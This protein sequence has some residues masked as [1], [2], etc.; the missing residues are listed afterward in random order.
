MYH[1]QI[2]V[3]KQQ[4]GRIHLYRES[5]RKAKECRLFSRTAS[6]VATLE[7]YLAAGENTEKTGT[8]TGRSATCHQWDMV[9]AV[10]RL[11]VEGSETRVVWRV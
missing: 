10:D 2:E 11:P 6:A 7:A 3:A 8:Q 9:C 5:Y 4:S 1:V